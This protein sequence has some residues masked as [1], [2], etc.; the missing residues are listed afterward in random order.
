MKL[1]YGERKESRKRGVALT[2]E[3]KGGLAKEVFLVLALEG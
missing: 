3:V 1:Q 2:L